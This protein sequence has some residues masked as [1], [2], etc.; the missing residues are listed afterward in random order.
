L[1][2][3]N[4]TGSLSEGRTGTPERG[5]KKNRRFPRTKNPRGIKALALGKSR[6]SR[7]FE[8]R[9]THHHTIGGRKKKTVRGYRRGLLPRCRHEGL[10]KNG[11]RNL[12]RQG[13][14]SNPVRESNPERRQGKMVYAT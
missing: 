5:K 8:K 13:T 2:G 12:K 1:T 11:W 10:E 6:K 3:H 9:S 7:V 14:S 4:V